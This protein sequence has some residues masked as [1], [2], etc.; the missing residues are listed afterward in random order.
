M[1]SWI[2]RVP[3]VVRKT[4]GDLKKKKKKEITEK[5]KI[6]KL[7]GA[8]LKHRRLK[9]LPSPAADTLEGPWH[10]RSAEPQCLHGPAPPTAHSTL[11]K[12]L[13]ESC[14]SACMHA[15]AGGF[16]IANEIFARA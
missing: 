12:R 7:F 16:L 8:S 11:D 10:S 3:E 5:K 4:K 6:L 14:P 13:G 2:Y 9:L 1:L 15:L